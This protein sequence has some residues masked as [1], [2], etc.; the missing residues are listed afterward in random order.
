[1][2]WIMSGGNTEIERRG[3]PP[4]NI[5]VPVVTVI[6]TIRAATHDRG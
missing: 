2:V 3:E 5:R 4:I 6:I 1:M